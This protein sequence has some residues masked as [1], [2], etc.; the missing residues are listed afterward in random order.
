MDEFAGSWAWFE[1][2]SRYDRDG[3]ET[4]A[5]LDLIGQLERGVPV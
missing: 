5:V 2:S 1:A 4:K 3:V